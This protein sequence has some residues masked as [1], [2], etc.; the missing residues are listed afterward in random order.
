MFVYEQDVLFETCVQV[1]LQT[2]LTNDG[3]VM[4]VDVGVDTI[5]ALENLAHQGRKCLGKRDAN[6]TGHDSLVVDAPLNPRHELLDIGWCRHLGWAF[7]VLIVLPEIL[8]PVTT[9]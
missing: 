7:E 1:G 6:A 2:K 8:E 3:V 4:A 9:C 5:H